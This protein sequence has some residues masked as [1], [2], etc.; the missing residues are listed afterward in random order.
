M[1]LKGASLS[2]DARTLQLLMLAIDNLVNVS[3]IR[4]IN[5][6]WNLTVPLLR[7]FLRADRPCITRLRRLWLEGC[8]LDGVGLESAGMSA[9]GLENLHMRLLKLEETL[10]EPDTIHVRS[11][12]GP[13]NRALPDGAGGAYFSPSA[14]EEAPR[15]WPCQLPPEPTKASDMIKAIDDGI[16]MKLPQVCAFLAQKQFS[17]PLS[18]VDTSSTAS[19]FMLSALQSSSTTLTSLSLDWIL[20]QPSAVYHEDTVICHE[21]PVFPTLLLELARLRFPHLRSFGLSNAGKTRTFYPRDVYLLRPGRGQSDELLS[22]I[23]AHPKIESLAWRMDRF[24]S[25]V[26]PTSEV[27]ARADAVIANLSRKLTHLRLESR[28]ISSYDL[29]TDNVLES[30][31]EP[32][33]ILRREFISGFAAHMTRLEQLE[34]EGPLPRDERREILRALGRC[35]LKAVVMLGKYCPIGNSWGLTGRRL[36]E[37]D[38]RQSDLVEFLNEE[39]VVS[40]PEL[41]PLPSASSGLNGFYRPSYGWQPGPPLLHALASCHASTITYLKFCGSDGSPILHSL[42][43]D[44]NRLLEPLCHFHRLKRLVLSMYLSDYFEDARRDQEIIRYWLDRRNPSSMAIVGPDQG[45]EENPWGVLLREKFSPTAIANATAAMLGPV[46]S[47]RAKSQPGGISLG[48]VFCM[49]DGAGDEFDLDMRLG[50]GDQVS[51]IVGPRE[52]D[53]MDRMR[54]RLES[55]EF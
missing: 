1:S 53:D 4:I 11:R 50:P 22:F 28:M 14:W 41:L 35:P 29:L 48:V 34:V 45:E 37:L 9:L 21:P 23:E 49:G 26:Q 25:P 38:P 31:K 7:G 19:S 13:L 20:S 55:R 3:T 39:Q 52:R 2:R 30:A 32:T 17:Q 10:V 15:S 43:R 36:M 47:E 16:Y 33:K 51:D 44:R 18:Y 5:G 24:F 40:V 27:A 8:S 12:Q 6:H 42:S 46:L 54:Q